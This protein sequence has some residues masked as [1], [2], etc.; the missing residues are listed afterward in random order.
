MLVA[1]IGDAVQYAV[2][3][4]NLGGPT[5]PEVSV[6]DRLPLGFRYIAGSARMAAGGAAQPLPDPAGGAGPVLTFAIPAQAESDEVL[7]TYRV[8]VGPGALQGDGVNR[9][10]AVSGDV[11]SNTALARV[12]VSG[13][14]F[15]TDACVVGVIF[16]DLNGNG[17]Q[18]AGE[19]GVPDVELHFEEGTSLVSDLEGKYSY[20]GLTPTTHVLKVDWTTLP[21]GAR[22]TTS[23]NR[24]AGDAGSLFVDLKFGEVHRTDFIV[25][26]SA[27][28]D[29]LDEI[30]VRRARA[31]VWVPKFDEPARP[32]IDRWPAG[33]RERRHL[34]RGCGRCADG[35][36]AGPDDRRI[37]SR[38]GRRA[39][40]TRRT[41][42]H[43][44]RYRLPP[45]RP[46]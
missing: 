22:L 3:V 42:M 20:C 32:A 43:R 21:A 41:R 24:N 36:D 2:R 14:V 5:L 26:A 6:T 18:D 9:A 30:G 1:E 35:T 15:T 28:P 33:D 7:I 29:V 34:P 44:S 8:R 46:R 31:E 13:G 39:A 11:R 23:S 37:R 16:A 25:D 19:P 17:L 12:L 40:S 45:T 38:S 27:S 10:D 4:R